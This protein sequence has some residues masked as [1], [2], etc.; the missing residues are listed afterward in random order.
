MHYLLL[1]SEGRW[2]IVSIWKG[3]VCQ[4]LAAVRRA[5]RSASGGIFR[6]PHGR[7]AELLVH[8]QRVP[9]HIRIHDLSIR[10]VNDGDA[11]DGDPLVCGRYSHEVAFVRTG[12]GPGD[13]YF[14]LLNNQ[15]LDGKAQIGESQDEAR[16]LTFVSFGADRRTGNIGI[17]ESVAGGDDLVHKL[18][19]PLIPNFLVKASN[20]GFAIGSHKKRPPPSD[21]LFRHPRR[22][23]RPH[24]NLDSL[25]GRGEAGESVLPKS[26]ACNPQ[27]VRSR[28]AQA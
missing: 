2:R 26:L 12:D 3:T 7:R 28:M 1:R 19:P 11:L 17:V 5:Q 23:A 24:A 20:D 21:G 15:I 13:R 14:F 18:E 6:L 25:A 8:P 4:K 22:W 16:N 9:T 10:N 27:T